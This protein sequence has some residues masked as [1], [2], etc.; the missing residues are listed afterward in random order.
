MLF[1]F[2]NVDKKTELRYRRAKAM[3]NRLK[4]RDVRFLSA[5]RVLRYEQSLSV[6]EF[7][8]GILAD[9]VEA[10]CN[11]DTDR[12]YIPDEKKAEV[13]VEK[14]PKVSLKRSRKTYI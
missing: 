13:V 3:K 11:M 7:V 14:T 6:E 8:R 10:A 12:V 5:E 1:S 4:K 9:C 2:L